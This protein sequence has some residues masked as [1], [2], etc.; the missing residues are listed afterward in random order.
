MALTAPSIHFAARPPGGREG[1]YT[2]R[3]IAAVAIIVSIAAFAYYSSRGAILFYKDSISHM[4][5]ARRLIDSPTPGFGQLGGVWLPLPHLLNAPLA[6]IDSFY[7]SGLAGS[8]VSMTAYVITSA[9]LYKITFTLTE[10]KLAGIVASAVFMANPNVL[11]LQSTPM[12]EL[13]LFACISGMIYGTQRW[14]QTDRSTYLVQAGIAGFLGTLTRYEA[15]IMLAAMFAVV[16]YVCWR[17]GYQYRRLE[18]TVLAF[19]Y[20]SALG[21]A[22]WMVWNTLIFGNPFYFQNGEYAKPSLWVDEGE[23][24]VGN[25]WVA[26]KTYF[27]AVTENLWL[28]VVVLMAV[29]IIVIIARERL[30]LSTLPMLSLIVLFPFFVFALHEGMRP[31]HV[32]Q[33]TNSVYNVRFGL[34][35]VLLAAISIGY[36]VSTFGARRDVMRSVAAGS[37]ALAGVTTLTGFA[38]DENVITLKEAIAENTS[39]YSQASDEASEYLS[40]NFTGGTVLM[41]SFGNEMVLFNAQISPRHIYEGSYQLWDPALQHPASNDIQ[42]IV[43]RYSTKYST[44]PDQVH[45]ALHG[46]DRLNEY[47][48]VFENEAYR[49]YRERP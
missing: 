48:L 23:Q 38:S 6:W 12:T 27:Y 39:G 4:E 28:P 44:Q 19:L 49:I 37:L 3:W 31:L 9:L 40:D 13:L 17:K 46:T 26:L 41:E 20:I 14:I 30:A 34:P 25:W 24:A 32:V 10:H 36:L 33:V 45:Q 8:F 16:V 15:W 5:I 7:Y 11:Y 22:G 42:W 35:M 21:I 2:A 29:G 43:S 47:E 1:D 18:G